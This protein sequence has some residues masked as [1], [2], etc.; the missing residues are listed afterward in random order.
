MVLSSYYG[1]VVQKQ[2]WVAELIGLAVKG[3]ELRPPEKVGNEGGREGGRVV[4]GLRL[5]K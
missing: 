5:C 1:E 4:G 2:P 3:L